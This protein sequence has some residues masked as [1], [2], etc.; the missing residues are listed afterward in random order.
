M[1][2]EQ[3]VDKAKLKA[4]IKEMEDKKR[5]GQVVVP[6]SVLVSFDS[7][8]HQRSGLIHAMH[9]KEIIL[10][11]FKARGLELEA[12]M[13]DFDNALKLYGVKLN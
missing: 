3:I 6:V 12:K 9:K 11:D 2:D 10:A 8:Y 4:K 5:E 7:W 1:S 13:E